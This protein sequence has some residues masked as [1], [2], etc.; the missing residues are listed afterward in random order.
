MREQPL[1][2]PDDSDDESY[3]ENN[4]HQTDWDAQ[5][6]VAGQDLDQLRSK[7]AHAEVSA[8]FLSVC[9]SRALF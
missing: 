4:R 7:L 6:Q 5:L 9:D 3:Q 1:A 2:F 8:S